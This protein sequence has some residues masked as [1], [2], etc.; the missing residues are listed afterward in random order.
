MSCSRAKMPNRRYWTDSE[1]AALKAGVA[2]HGVGKWVSILRDDD[3]GPYLE[4]RTNINLKD[5]WRSLQRPSKLHFDGMRPKKRKYLNPGEQIRKWPRRVRKRSH[6]T[7][8]ETSFQRPRL[9]PEPTNST[10]LTPK[11]NILDDYSRCTHF[12]FTETGRKFFPTTGFRKQSIEFSLQNRSLV[13]CRYNKR[14]VLTNTVTG[15]ENIRRALPVFIRHD[16][17][18]FN[19]EGTK[20]FRNFK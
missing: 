11:E 18:C 13:M 19:E 7:G 10:A 14:G 1:V 3:F 12:C 17:S 6:E 9:G 15:L 8:K 5:K 16:A 2:R 20:S 4:D